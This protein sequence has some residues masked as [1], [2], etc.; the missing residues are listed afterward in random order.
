[1][2]KRSRLATANLTLALELVASVSARAHGSRKLLL[3]CDVT[4]RSTQLPPGVHHQLDWPQ[5]A[6][7]RHSGQGTQPG[8]HS[9]RAD[10]GCQQEVRLEGRPF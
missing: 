10:G 4:L 9:P 8:C 2:N 5:P 3:R 1:M 7:N 6:G